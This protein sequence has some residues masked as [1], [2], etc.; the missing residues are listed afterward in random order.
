MSGNNFDKFTP[1][2]KKALLFAEQEAR[3]EGIGYI[4]TEHLLLGVLSQKETLGSA[5][6]QHFGIT[7]DNIKTILEDSNTKRQQRERRAKRTTGTHRIC[8][9]D[10]KRCGECRL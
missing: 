4:G 5:V 2:A 8:Q 7:Q 9:K 6:L 10:Y 3:A 1:E